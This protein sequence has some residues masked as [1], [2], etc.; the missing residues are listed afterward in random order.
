MTVRT[1]IDKM[2]RRSFDGT[3]VLIV[4]K[5]VLVSFDVFLFVICFFE[6]FSLYSMD[7]DAFINRYF[8][9]ESEN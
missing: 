6:V 7:F 3:D 4:I 9:K 2:Q 8:L 5:C 1:N